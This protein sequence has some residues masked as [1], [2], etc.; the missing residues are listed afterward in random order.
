LDTVRLERHLWRVCVLNSTFFLSAGP[1]LTELYLRK[2]EIPSLQELRYL[3]AS[4]ARGRK[5]LVDK[6]ERQSERKEISNTSIVFSRPWT[7]CNLLTSLSLA[8]SCRICAT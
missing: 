8:P 4:D 6:Q 2:N 1:L 7:T 5:V 3:Q